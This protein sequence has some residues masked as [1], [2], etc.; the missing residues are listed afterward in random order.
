MGHKYFDKFFKN[1]SMQ[2][3]DILAGIWGI[4]LRWSANVLVAS[5]ATIEIIG[6]GSLPL[7]WNF[8]LPS[9]SETFFTSEVS[10][11]DLSASCLGSLHA[12]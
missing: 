2:F 5:V 12:F 9:N 1:K 7:S 6:S 4:S 11:F 3:L 8:P 10:V